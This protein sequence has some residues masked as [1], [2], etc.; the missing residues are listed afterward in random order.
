[1]QVASGK[2]LEHEDWYP[3]TMFTAKGEDIQDV[4]STSFYNNAE[5]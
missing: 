5:V 3:L 2:Q 4:N 1:M